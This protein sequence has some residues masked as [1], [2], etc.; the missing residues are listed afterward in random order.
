MWLAAVAG[1]A[2]LVMFV[3]SNGRGG[4]MLG[5]DRR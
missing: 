1:D 4:E 2:Y 5:A 3:S